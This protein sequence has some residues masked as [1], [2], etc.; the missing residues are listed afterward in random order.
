M[1][2]TFLYKLATF[3]PLQFK[4]ATKGVLIQGT[5]TL[6]KRDYLFSE[7]NNMWSTRDLDLIG[8]GL[9]AWK[10]IILDKCKDPFII[11][12]VTFEVKYCVESKAVMIFDRFWL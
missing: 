5:F 4:A 8:E 10:N 7:G 12:P 6:F 9:G 11:G 2:N 3:D 1:K